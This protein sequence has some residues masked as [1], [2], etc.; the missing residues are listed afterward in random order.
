M[1]VC[2]EEL[3]DHCGVDRHRCGRRQRNERTLRDFCSA[4]IVVIVVAAAEI[5]YFLI[6]HSFLS[7]GVYNGLLI[8]PSPE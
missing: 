8:L 1:R 2:T 7:L 4:E 5:G 3:L 6:F